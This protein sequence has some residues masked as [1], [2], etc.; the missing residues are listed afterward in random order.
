MSDLDQINKT[1]IEWIKSTLTEIKEQTTRT[2][3]RVNQLEAFRAKVYTYG[4]IALLA[5]PYLINKFI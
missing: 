3:G 5:V 4:T 1:D 2:N